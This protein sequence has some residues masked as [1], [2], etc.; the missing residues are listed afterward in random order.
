[1]LD[2]GKTGP[3]ILSLLETKD[4]RALE[5]LRATVGSAR[6]LYVVGPFLAIPLVTRTSLQLK[7]FQVL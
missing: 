2:E 7:V 5:E 4:P 1:M 3:T 6:V